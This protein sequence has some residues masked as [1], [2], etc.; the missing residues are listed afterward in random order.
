MPDTYLPLCIIMGTLGAVGG[1]LGYK[2][3]RTWTGANVFDLS[4]SPDAA[5]NLLMGTTQSREAWA[6]AARILKMRWTVSS[7]TE[8][9][10]EGPLHGRRVRIAVQLDPPRVQWRA[11][12]RAPMKDASFFAV[13]SGEAGDIATG[14]KIFDAVYAVRAQ[15]LE[16]ALLLLPVGIRVALLQQRATLSHDAVTGFTREVPPSA[17]DGREVARFVRL[18]GESFA[19]LANDL[20][21]AVARV[22]DAAVVDCDTVEATR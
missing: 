7:N 22:E 12:L 8:F 18:R 17:A 16:S 3:I 6:D 19:E 15:S 20:D 11:P 4:T 9:E 5:G 14:D 10:L 1:G 21:A 2:L 13:P